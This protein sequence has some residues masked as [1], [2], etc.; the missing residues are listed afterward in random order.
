MSSGR[1]AAVALSGAKQ[2][3]AQHRGRH[4]AGAVLLFPN[5]LTASPEAGEDPTYLPIARQSRLPIAILQGGKSPWHWQLDT[6]KQQLAKGGS[7]VVI[8]NLPGMRDRFYFRDD[9]SAQ[10]RELGDRLD[11]LIHDAIQTLPGLKSGGKRK[12]T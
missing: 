11:Y 4:I 9:A 12:A 2:W 6:L 1:G 8:K 5:L 7:R 10:E 3:Q